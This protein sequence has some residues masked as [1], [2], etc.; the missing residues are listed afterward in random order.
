VA[1]NHIPLGHDY[2]DLHSHFL[3][4]DRENRITY[5]NI[6][7]GCDWESYGVNALQGV[8]LSPL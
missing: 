7:M 4:L 1:A 2:A 5:D 6:K 8:L 3:A